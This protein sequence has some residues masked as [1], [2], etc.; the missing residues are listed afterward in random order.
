M[1]K[2]IYVILKKLNN[3]NQLCNLKDDV[4]SVLFLVINNPWKYTLVIDYRYS[5][6]YNVHTIVDQTPFKYIFLHS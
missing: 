5:L 3:F 6:I 1:V 2:V 4:L